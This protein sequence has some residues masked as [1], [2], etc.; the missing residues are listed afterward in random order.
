MSK[1]SE[2]KHR[3]SKCQARFWAEMGTHAGDPDCRSDNHDKELAHDSMIPL[4][5]ARTSTRSSRADRKSKKIS[6]TRTLVKYGEVRG[7]RE[8][9]EMSSCA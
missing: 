7:E 2:L 5:G 8:K 1:Y 4:R 6:M 3:F 9:T